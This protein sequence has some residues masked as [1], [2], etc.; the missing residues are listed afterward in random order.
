MRLV[1]ATLTVAT[2]LTAILM[3]CSGSD[4]STPRAVAPATPSAALMQATQPAAPA[5]SAA[6]STL[7]PSG[8]ASGAGETTA[9]TEA[10]PGVVAEV[11]GVAV[12]M[13]DFQRQLT[14]ARTYLLS[15]GLIDPDTEEGQARLEALRDQVLGQ[16]IDQALIIQAAEQMGLSVSDDELEESIANIKAALPSE[17]A[18]AESLAANNLTEEE[19]RSLQRQQLLSWKVMD[20]I[21]A[22]VPDEAE[23]V[24]ARHILVE[25]EEDAKSILEQLESGADFAEL[26][27]EHSTDETTKENG[28]D[29]G[30]FP[31]GV[32]LAE[33]E[34]A[35]FAL[36]VG[37]RSGVVQTPYGYHIIEVLARETRPVPD[38]IKEGLRQQIIVNW[39][40]TQRAQADIERYLDR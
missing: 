7:T 24:H 39:L 17:D 18:F 35:A 30:F 12:P 5:A 32:V 2:L 8:P 11:N 33:F 10:P 14:D 23:Q 37:E 36:A 4:T 3:A 31:R 20:K 13:S 6:V 16:L 21:T 1:P 22:D 38:E 25:T 28:G 19:F 26:A 34:E 40:D 9:T 15:E 29:L 27:R